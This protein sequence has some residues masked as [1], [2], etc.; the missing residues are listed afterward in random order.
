[1]FFNTSFFCLLSE[2]LG[3]AKIFYK[4]LVD[5]AQ[6]HWMTRAVQ[7]N[8]FVICEANLL[9]EKNKHVIYRAKS[10]RMGKNFALGLKYGPRPAAS[11]R[12][13]DL[14]HSFFPYGPP[15]R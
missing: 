4:S 3:V 5:G 14:G 1:M 11:G 8:P 10:V 9:Q 12:T 2:L 15:A 13:Q 6:A 7:T